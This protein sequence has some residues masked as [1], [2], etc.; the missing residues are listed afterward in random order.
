MIGQPQ[1]DF[2]KTSCVTMVVTHINSE[3]A[4]R[5]GS[6]EHTAINSSPH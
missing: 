1:N 4:G 2:I 5:M 6:K 3:Q